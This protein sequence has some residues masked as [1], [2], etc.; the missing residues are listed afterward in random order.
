MWY[1]VSWRRCLLTLLFEGALWSEQ[2][3]RVD[4]K[5][6]NSKVEKHTNWLFSCF[7][8]VDPWDVAVQS[9]EENKRR[10]SE[11]YLYEKSEIIAIRG[12]STSWSFDGYDSFAISRWAEMDKLGSSS[13]EGQKIADIRTKRFKIEIRGCSNKQKQ[14][15]LI[16]IKQKFF[17]TKK[18]EQSRKVAESQIAIDWKEKQLQLIWDKDN[19]EDKREE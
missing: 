16:D 3:W 9:Q 12:A 1:L 18:E 19:I 13:S 7:E 17:D 2:H 11:K 14:S 15:F 8:R 5:A 4:K 6:E 10:Q